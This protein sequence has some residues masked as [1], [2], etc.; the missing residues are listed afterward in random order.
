MKVH[1]TGRIIG[2]AAAMV[3]VGAGIAGMAGCGRVMARMN[4]HKINA[5]QYLI[6]PGLQASD[7]QFADRLADAGLTTL[8]QYRAAHAATAPLKAL[9]QSAAIMSEFSGGTPRHARKLERQ[10]VADIALYLRGRPGELDGYWALDQAR[11]IYLH[12]TSP[13]AK[14]VRFVADT[15]ATRRRLAASAGVFA[16]L[17]NIADITLYGMMHYTENLEP[18]TNADEAQYAAAQAGHA[19]ASYLM[20]Q[21]Q[22][23]LGLAAAPGPQRKKYMAQCVR[24]LQPW[25]KRGKRTG[26]LYQSWLLAGEASSAAGEFSRA[27]S[28]LRKAAVAQAPPFVQYNAR[29]QEVLLYAQRKRFDKATKILDAFQQWLGK[30]PQTSGPGAKVGVEMLSY[31]VEMIRARSLPN[32]AA[33]AAA[34]KKA[35][36]ILHAIVKANPSF[37]PLVYEQIAVM[38]S[39]HAGHYKTMAPLQALALAWKAAQKNTRANNL[40]ALH[41]ARAVRKN[42]HASKASRLEATL[43]EGICAGR[44]GRLSAAA[45]LNVAYVTMAP[46]DPKSKSVLALALSQLAKLT[47]TGHASTKVRALLRKALKLAYVNLGEKR[48]AF[49][50]ADQLEKQKKFAQAAAMFDKVPASSPLYLDAHYRLLRIATDRLSRLEDKKASQRLRLHAAAQLVQR[51]DQF[52]QVLRRPPATVAGASVKRARLYMPDIYLI[53]AST[54]LSPLRNPKAAGKDLTRLQAMG[55][56]LTPAVRSAIL[57]YRIRQYQLEHKNSK[58]LQVVDQIAGG[59]GQNKQEVIKGL[60]GQWDAQSR[61]LR[62]SHP[63]RAKRLAGDAAALLSQLIKQAGAQLN[64]KRDV[65]GYQQILADTLIRAGQATKAMALFKQLQHERP[66]DIR[67]F[68]GQ[69][70]AA[71]YAK[72]YPYSHDFWVRII[73]QLPPGSPSFWDGYYFVIKCNEKMHKNVKATRDSLE[74]LVTIYGSA[75]GGK[76]R[77]KAFEKFMQEYGVH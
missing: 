2:P 4:W 57:R 14:Q 75:I 13:L 17:V 45:R 10:Y 35:V 64:A 29:Y 24:L 74:S 49:A 30:S 61:R 44:L 69:A 42:A 22:Y 15:A 72:K 8:L 50:Y 18:F 47:D 34:R 40:T 70:R 9:Y 71:Y 33:Q 39:G 12:I 77:H 25:I 68:I 32:A 11:F 37:A 59:A 41:A 46:H 58:V 51:S 55:A 38:N 19:G 6:M 66:A 21:A 54:N 3:L 76:R 7:T 5:K 65:Y 31:R 48:W 53:L 20:P 27:L 56:D 28:D 23:Q 36:G 52:L 67:N 26:V 43:I 60:I 73:E 1:R 62:K 63:A 16:K